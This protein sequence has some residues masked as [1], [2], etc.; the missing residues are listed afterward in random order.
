MSS[1]WGADRST[2]TGREAAHAAG[3]DPGSQADP[4]W[5]VALSSLA[6]GEAADDAQVHC[7]A[8]WAQ[9]AEVR[10]RWRDYHLIG[11]ALRS[12]DLA[13]GGA[14]DAAFL[15]TLRDRLAHEPVVLRPAAAA[16]RRS[17]AWAVPVAAA[18]GVAAVAGVTLVLRTSAPLQTQQQTL[19]VRAASQPVVVSA[20]SQ[21]SAV[22]VG[23]AAQA[24][25]QTLN[26]RL[27][28]DAR[29]DRYLAAH[30]QSA[31][32]AALQVPGA[33]LRNVDTIVL[34]DR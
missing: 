32:G 29:L 33:G 25:A 2:G 3:G 10:E 13:R 28:R 22:A 23:R 26:G 9:Q 18:A 7:L 34:E 8:V 30:R 4:A 15:A 6:D 14:R 1:E 21:P 11:D 17:R 24:A 31:T 27:I 5:A 19:A 20:A 16:Q 12:G